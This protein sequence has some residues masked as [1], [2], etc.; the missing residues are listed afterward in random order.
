[1]VPIPVTDLRFEG[2]PT[3]VQLG[4]TKSQSSSRKRKFETRKDQTQMRDTIQ[5]QNSIVENRKPLQIGSPS[6]S[7]MSGK[8]SV[9]KKKSYDAPRPALVPAEE[10][11]KETAKHRRFQS[12]EADPNIIFEPTPVAPSKREEEF[13]DEDE[14]SDD[15]DAPEAITAAAGFETSRST[16][17]NAARTARTYGFLPDSFV[18]STN[19]RLDKALLYEP[20]GEKKTHA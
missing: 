20:N 4:T 5:P 3:T 13:E 12:E 1:M 17:L 6:T 2:T 9:V 14:S 7:K 18:I 11:M 15:D 16:T 10:S 19:K 8:S